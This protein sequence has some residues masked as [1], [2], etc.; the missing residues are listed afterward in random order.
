[1]KIA[2]SAAGN[3]L[4]SPVDPRFG[5]CRYF[6]IIDTDTLAFEAVE[7]PNMGLGGG[8]GIQS[9]QLVAEKGARYLLTGNCGPNAFQTLSAAGIGIITGCTGLV[10]ETVEQ[11]R[12]KGLQASPDAN[13]SSHFG[14][15][16]DFAGPSN[17]FM[18][19]NMGSGGGRGRGGGRGSGGRGSGGRGS[20]G[21]GGGRGRG[22]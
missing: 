3:S 9:A 16:A 20:G 22:L 5:R 1:M 17:P 21:R 19:R 18:G 2:V 11:F 8:A 6:L 4:E 15:G 12:S 13:V 10:R 7:N 14:V